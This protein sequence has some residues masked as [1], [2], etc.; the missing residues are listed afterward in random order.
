MSFKSSGWAGSVGALILALAATKN[1]S[2]G[3]WPVQRVYVKEA[4]ILKENGN[5][6]MR[7]VYEA[8]AGS[9]VLTSAFGCVPNHSP[10]AGTSNQYQAAYWNGGVDLHHQNYLSSLLAAQAQGL[11]VDIRFNSSGCNTN[12]ST[13]GLGGLGREMAGVKVVSE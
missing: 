1:V 13:Y 9:T 10:I 5:T 6:I 3:D 8:D 7:V 2:A 12:G 11:P 4:H